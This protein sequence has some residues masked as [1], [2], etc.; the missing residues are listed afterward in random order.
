MV[1]KKS[2]QH[3]FCLRKLSKFQV[4]RTLTTTF[5][6]SFIELMLTTVCVGI[7]RIQKCSQYGGQCKCKAGSPHLLYGSDTVGDI[8]LMHSNLIKRTKE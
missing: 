2:Q 3:L 5:Y 7:S 6:Q 8:K 4:N 1:Y